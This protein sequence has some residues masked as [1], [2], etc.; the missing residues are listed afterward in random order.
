MKRNITKRLAAWFMVLCF[1]LMQM[2]LPAGCLKLDLSFL[3]AHAEDTMISWQYDKTSPFITY[4]INADG[5][6]VTANKYDA[7]K[8][9]HNVDLGTMDKELH[10]AD[11]NGKI[12]DNNGT[13]Y[14]VTGIADSCMSGIQTFISVV[15]PKTVTRIGNGAFQNCWENFQTITFQEG[16]QC[17]SIGN[18]AFYDCKK[19]GTQGETLVL[20]KSLQSVGN[21]AFTNCTSLK[22]VDFTS[23]WTTI[24]KEAFLKNTSLT[25][26]HLPESL[27]PTS[28]GSAATL[29]G[30]ATFS[31][32]TNLVAVN[33]PNQTE[34]PAETFKGCSQLC[35]TYADVNNT[36]V[37]KEELIK[38]G[39]ASLDF[40]S[41]SLSNV[42]TIGANAFE[43][44]SFD[45]LVFSKAITLIDSAAFQK[46]SVT[47]I[48][49][50]H[51]DEDTSHELVIGDNAFAKTSK[52]DQGTPIV[53]A[54]CITKLGDSA[55]LSSKVAQAYFH[56]GTKI[57]TI[58]KA[59][60]SG[61]ALTRFVIPD[62]I[63]TISENM[64]NSCINLDTVS[65]P[66]TLTTIGAGAFNNAT[67]FSNLQLRSQALNE[68]TEQEGAGVEPDLTNSNIE[69]IGKE[70]FKGSG[71]TS[72]T[73]PKK[74]T[75]L[76]AETFSGCSQ[77]TTFK[78]LAGSSATTP[79]T[80]GQSV[81]YK[82]S[83]LTNIAI[84]YG[85]ENWST[86]VFDGCSKL[87]NVTVGSNG[88]DA[89]SYEK[90]PANTFKDCE[91]LEEFKLPSTCT[92]IDSSA[93]K[94]C[95]SFTKISPTS[96]LETINLS[97]FENCTS[98]TGFEGASTLA[99][100]AGLM[101][102]G[103][104]A[105]AGCT[106]LTAVTSTGLIPT[107]STSTFAGCTNLTS[108]HLGSKVSSIGSKAFDNVPIKEL[109]FGNTTATTF[110]K[111]SFNFDG[112]SL[113]SLT[114]YEDQQETYRKN[115]EDKC[116]I[117]IP[118]TKFKT[119][120]R[121]ADD[122]SQKTPDFE[123]GIGTTKTLTK[124]NDFTLKDASGGSAT[125]NISWKIAD[126]SI[127][128][129]TSATDGST[130]TV[131]GKT[132]GKTSLVG[133]VIGTT[134]SIVYAV[135]VTPSN[136]STS[137][138]TNPYSAVT[139]YD[140]SSLTDAELASN[141]TI[142]AAIKDANIQPLSNGKIYYDSNG[143]KTETKTL[144]VAGT[145]TAAGATSTDAL[146]WRFTNDTS[147]A[148]ATMTAPAGTEEIQ[149]KQT[150]YKGSLIRLAPSTDAGKISVDAVSITNQKRTVTF[151]IQKV[152]Q[153]I[154]A[155]KSINV[156]VHQTVNLNNIASIKKEP[157][158]SAETLLY[159]IPEEQQD[160]ATIDASGNLTANKMGKATVTVSSSESATRT[161]IE[162]NVCNPIKG[163]TITKTEANNTPT[164]I[165]DKAT[166]DVFQGEVLNL[167]F[168]TQISDPTQN[169]TDQLQFAVTT[170]AIATIGTPVVENNV[171]HLTVTASGTGSTPLTI[172]GT[173]SNFT[174]TL[175]L[176]VKTALNSIS[177]DETDK[178]KTVAIGDSLDLSKLVKS[179]PTNHNE[180]LT[181]E[182]NNTS[183]ATVTERGVVTTVSPGTALITVYCHRTGKSAQ[184][185]ITADNTIVSAKTTPTAIGSS[186]EP[187]YPGASKSVTLEITKKNE[188]FPASDAGITWSSTNEDVATVSGGSLTGA[189]I[190]AVKAGRTNVVVKNASG[191]QLA[192]IAITVATPT[193]K[194]ETSNVTLYT[195]IAKRK[196]YT[197]KPIINGHDKTV[198]YKVTKGSKYVK[199]NSKGK[200]TYKNK[201]KIGA[202]IVTVTANGVSATLSVNI[203]K[204]T[205]KKLSVSNSAGQIKK[206]TITVKKSAGT[207]T[208]RYTASWNAL[209][210]T[211]KSSK[212]KVA[213][214]D[215]KGL[216]KLKKKGTTKITTTVDGYKMTYTLKVK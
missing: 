96:Q 142:E 4:Q 106:K 46:S 65:I 23:E 47:T 74:V 207:C 24:G 45:S 173:E 200:V 212:K 152:V 36:K 78:F 213:S 145:L 156:Q 39:K 84:P 81:F 91:K 148:I 88:T 215:S 83:V 77:L 143:T 184:F 53:F 102:L 139:I 42:T 66:K 12:T 119:K 111:D 48:S 136:A 92:I 89:S 178:N 11:D 16:S 204:V 174:T 8:T 125:S 32:C 69:T 103:G 38:D 186:D 151:S 175:T 159:S 51:C 5:V 35:T 101:T 93:F 43:G 189:T 202:A 133:T 68:K 114:C 61:A 19:L 55:F 85:I 140:V 183:V 167:N 79:Y 116:G 29:T 20:P 17:V 15:I 27:P 70:A 10:I 110:L 56:A 191:K 87:E 34:I 13:S 28:A 201:K 120:Q 153:Q 134:C 166:I 67:A 154:S 185:T 94:N 40:T 121:P 109:E 52:I 198:T 99:L 112:A 137:S 131:T 31:G 57:K 195:K 41:G 25:T 113:T 104:N 135:Y 180:T 2:N 3:N 95:S 177:V 107:V 211:Y 128:T 60:F 82:C 150:Y 130:V 80:F 170:P 205:K 59:A 141:A 118:S 165:S 155:A 210:I 181:W 14:V 115:F 171:V 108:V 179:N 188:S 123:I 160:I 147:A 26:V 7:Q 62:C 71:L 163:V 169:S 72:F 37:N 21:G 64:F 76:A 157:A 203:D 209:K 30:A 187:F 176:R 97:A 100:P 58:G 196:S 146:F 6:T 1:V 164:T 44:T 132:I 149:N 127:A 208:S 144:Y 161:T 158:T 194:L 193:I 22:T 197:I 199:V 33:I 98:L 105:F 73:L 90:L 172:K 18:N 54:N 138:I 216:I 192:S 49:F 162:V 63:D 214:I 129:M 124:N 190:T 168:E 182:S 9:E 117:I 122:V 126:E 75:N 206:K 86:G 50:S